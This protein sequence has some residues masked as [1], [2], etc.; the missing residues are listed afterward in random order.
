MVDLLTTTPIVL[1]ILVLI[2]VVPAIFKFVKWI[3]DI[4]KK[5]KSNQAEAEARGRALE[6]EDHAEEE[7]FEKGEARIGEL[8]KKEDRLETLLLN[9][10]KQLNYLLDYNKNAIRAQVYK[11]WKKVIAHK[12]IDTQEY[13]LLEESFELY[14]NTGGNGKTA[15]RMAEIRKYMISVTAASV[16]SDE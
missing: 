8:E 4:V 9:Q 15:A 1:I 13:E 10:Q 12:P 2:I 7:R 5:H 3:L 16:D 11:M 6:Q 14:Q